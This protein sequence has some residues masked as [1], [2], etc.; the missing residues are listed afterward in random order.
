MRIA[1]MGAG[2]VSDDPASPGSSTLYA[3]LKTYCEGVAR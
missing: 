1:G 2:G 3:A